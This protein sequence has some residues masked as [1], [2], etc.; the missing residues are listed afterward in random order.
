MEKTNVR[1]RLANTDPFVL[2]GEQT[3]ATALE[4]SAAG[5]ITDQH[6][7]SSRASCYLD[8]EYEQSANTLELGQE[9]LL[10]PDFS[11]NA[12]TTYALPFGLTIG[13]GVQYIDDI[14]R[15][16]TAALG[17]VVVPGYWLFDAMA[18]YAIR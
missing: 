3:G 4:L 18:S 1:T 2:D 17:E 8:S 9:L 11:V 10:T 14:V 15:S 16:R 6:G 7:R 13:A 12:W 5:S